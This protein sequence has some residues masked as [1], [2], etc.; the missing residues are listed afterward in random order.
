MILRGMS[1][2]VKIKMQNQVISELRRF[3]TFGAINTLLTFMLCQLLIFFLSPDISY[4]ISWG[5]GIVLVCIYYPRF[6]FRVDRK[7]SH[8]VKTITLYVFSFFLGLLT[9]DTLGYLEVNERLVILITVVLTTC[10]NFI[11]SKVIYRES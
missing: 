9:I 7:L 8:V 11:V 4:A 2:S 5:V 6:V 3:F 10:F 1:A